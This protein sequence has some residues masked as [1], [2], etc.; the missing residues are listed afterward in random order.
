MNS[1]NLTGMSVESLLDELHA[2]DS[3]LEELV[4][5]RNEVRKAL[6]HHKNGIGSTTVNSDDRV[7]AIWTSQNNMP[8]DEMAKEGPTEGYESPAPRRY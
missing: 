3:G 8:S 5:R 6:D 2:L 7:Y 4:N 1:S